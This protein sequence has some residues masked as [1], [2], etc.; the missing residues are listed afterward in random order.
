A[1]GRPAAA[2][3]AAVHGAGQGIPPRR[4]GPAAHAARATAHA[5]RPPPGPAVQPGG[6]SDDRAAPPAAQARPGKNSPQR[7]RRPSARPH[8]MVT[9]RFPVRGPFHLWPTSLAA[10]DRPGQVSLVPTAVRGSPGSVDTLI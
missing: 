5:A 1:S 4:A 3:G 10:A 2:P 6:W 8:I 7:T 9:G